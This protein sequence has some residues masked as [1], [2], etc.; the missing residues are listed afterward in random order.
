[1]ANLR[2]LLASLNTLA[3]KLDEAACLRARTAAAVSGGAR[4]GSG[5]G[6]PWEEGAAWTAALMPSDGDISITDMDAMLDRA[7]SVMGL[8]TCS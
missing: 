5:R 3:A 7:L 8:S 1:M 2:T 4:Q 6:G